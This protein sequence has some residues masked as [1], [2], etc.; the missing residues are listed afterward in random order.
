MSRFLPAYLFI[1]FYLLSFGCTD[2]HSSS[3]QSVHDTVYTDRKSGDKSV[4]G[5]QLVG[6]TVLTASKKNMEAGA[7]HGLWLDDFKSS[8]CLQPQSETPPPTEITSVKHP[9]D[10]TLIITANINANC[11]YDFLG[12]IEIVS[13]NTLNLI[14]HGYGGYASC[15]CCFGL[16]YKI[17]IVRNDDYRFDK[18]KYVTIDGIAKTSIPKL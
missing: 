12:E 13:D 15:N 18:L 11:S 7:V 5:H 4:S 6:T 10:S 14:Y 8:Q 17:K 16:T 1:F 3:A 2:Q 9:N